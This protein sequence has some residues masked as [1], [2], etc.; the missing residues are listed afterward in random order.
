MDGY[1]GWRRRGGGTVAAACSFNPDQ[2]GKAVLDRRPA[3]LIRDPAVHSAVKCRHHP[4]AAPPCGVRIE[5]FRSVP[6]SATAITVSPY[7]ARFTVAAIGSTPAS[8]RAPHAVHPGFRRPWRSGAFR[9]RVPP[10]SLGSTH[11][12]LARKGL[13]EP[14][15][16]NP[17][18]TTGAR[19]GPQLFRHPT[20][21][22]RAAAT[23]S[24]SAA[25]QPLTSTGRRKR[26]TCFGGASGWTQAVGPPRPTRRPSSL[27]ADTWLRGTANV[28]G[29]SAMWRCLRSFGVK[30]RFVIT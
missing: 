12:P 17:R 25:V 8:R 30:V 26:T 18:R 24:A 23:V 7:S 10:S 13:G 19:R 4:L 22:D 6:R 1:G 29:P 28:V 16:E 21:V 9:P 3:A 5:R 15:Q 2:R 27:P 14:C 20:L 11:R